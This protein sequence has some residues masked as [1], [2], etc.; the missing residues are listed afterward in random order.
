MSPG[1]DS[2]FWP[3]LAVG[4]LMAVVLWLVLLL[5]LAQ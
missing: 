3:G 5:W 1:P 2:G 4:T